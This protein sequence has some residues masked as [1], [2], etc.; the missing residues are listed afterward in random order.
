MD[1]EKPFFNIVTAAVNVWYRATDIDRKNITLKATRQDQFILS[2]IAS[3]ILKKWMKIVRF[4]VFLNDRGRALA[5][6]GSA[7]SKFVEKDGELYCEVVPW[8][9]LICDPVD[10]N[11]N[12]K[13]ER[14]WLTP[15]QLR[16]RKEYD[17]EMV[18]TLIEAREARETMDGQKK[19]NKS[20]YIELFEVHGMLPKVHLT[21]KES[22]EDVYVQQMHVVSYLAKKDGVK[23]TNQFDDYT[24]YRGKETKD[25]YRIDHLIK[26]DGRTLAIGAVEHLSEVQWM[27]NHT[28]KQIKDH[29]DLASKLI[30][31]TS[32]GNFVGQ[33][34]LNAIETGDILIHQAGQPLTELNNRSHDISAI[35]AF[36]MQWKQLANEITGISES[37]MGANPPSGTAWRQ[38]EALL[39]ESH[40]LFELMTENKGLAIE[41]MMTD[42]I[43]PYIKKKM[44]TTE[45]ISE[46]LED[47]Q[48]KKLD[49][50]YV[51][52]EA[53]KR[54]KKK[55]IDNVL[56]RTPE[57][58][59]KGRIMTGDMKDQ[60]I[61][62]EEEFL[63]NS[64][65]QFGN[66]RF[67]K[68]SEIDSKTWKESLKDFEWE[69][70]VDATGESK[71]RQ[72]IMTT[73]ST[74]LQTVAQ[75][76]AQG[77]KMPPEMKLIFNKILEHTGAISAI[78]L[79]TMQVDS[80]N[81]PQMMQPQMQPQMAQPPQI[82]A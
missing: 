14:I 55:I 4:G 74:V 10:F 3:I 32:D 9:R 31:Q 33:N 51:P 53:R 1:R 50:M 48:I 40:S 66:Q 18:E 67:I 21:D 16:E 80:D 49:A 81:Q 34:V 35:Q 41:E 59:Q 56:S 7:V 39:Q 75:F 47:Y 11:N 61:A 44:D 42:F 28:V 43:I 65:K 30:F 82:N 63:Q 5:R 6:Y 29:L 72:S 12:I 25:P 13:I 70:D 24:L 22:D 2:F 79:D 64:L 26:E 73:L 68:P 52:K 27:Q 19:D 38:T 17:Q 20:E 77:M 36:G 58:L 37:M 45:E 69:S 54:A 62:G 8:N 78:E 23:S 76:S 46:I 60:I 15:A 57:D 71:D